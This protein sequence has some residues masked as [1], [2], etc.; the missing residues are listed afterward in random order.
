MGGNEQRPLSNIRVVDAGHMLAGP[1]CGTIF[2]EFGA[3][4]IKVEHPQF[5][6]PLRRFG[7]ID[8]S[9]G[10]GLVWCVEA[11]N[12]KSITLNL[13]TREGAELFKELARKSDI[14]IESFRP[15]TMERWGLG[16]EDLA[17]VNPRIIMVRVSG[18]GQTGPYRHRPGFA[19]VAHAF[20]G[21]TYLSGEPDRPPTVPGSTSLADYMAGM[22][23]AIGAFVALHE[24]SRSG[25]GQVVDIALYEAVMRVLDEVIPLYGRY[26]VVRERMGADVPHIVPHSHYRTRDGRWIALAGSTDKMWVRIA[27]MIG[28][29]ELAEDDRFKTMS[30][31]IQNRDAV[32]NLLA[33]WFA[34]L[35]AEEAISRCE[36]AE[37]PCS[38]IYSVRDMFEDEHYRQRGDLVQHPDSRWGEVVMPRV[39]PILSRTPGSIVWGGPALGEHNEEIY[40]DLLGLSSQEIASLREKGVI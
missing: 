32:N 8:P 36:E 4:V 35:D 11:R 22:W 21:L 34:T 7:T 26:G 31:R 29:P 40:G 18:Y 20:G 19:R 15:G 6:D 28:K 37:V 39:V 5:G 13:S 12:K 9:T 10:D 14:V 30:A 16:Y 24:R 2:A 33:D 3:E 25:R 27:S 1:F 23:A 17:A 38:L